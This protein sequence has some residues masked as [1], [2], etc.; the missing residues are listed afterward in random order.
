VRLVDQDEM[1]REFDKLDLRVAAKIIAVAR[2]RS[3]LRKEV[4]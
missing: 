3:R 4:R 2:S 1:R